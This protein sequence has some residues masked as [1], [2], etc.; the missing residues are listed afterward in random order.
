MR[1]LSSDLVRLRALLHAQAA[2]AGPLLA[3]SAAS[4]ASGAHLA[5]ARGGWRGRGA[6]R[7]GAGDACWG[8]GWQAAWTAGAAGAAVGAACALAACRWAAHNK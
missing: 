1:A 7:A 2:P 4:G 5:A 8:G 6:P 3:A